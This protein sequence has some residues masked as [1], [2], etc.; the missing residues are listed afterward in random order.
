M[1]RMVGWLAVALVAIGACAAGPAWV[2][3]TAAPLPAGAEAVPIR[4][5]PIPTSIADDA[6]FGCP[7]ALMG[8]TVMVVD[9]SVTPPA[10]SYRSAETGEPVELAWSWG[11][12]AYERDGVVHIVAP[13]GADMM[14]EGQVADDLGGG[15]DNG[16]VFGVCDFR[17]MPR[18]VGS[19]P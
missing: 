1:R 3:P 2:F 12:S 16:N 15:F 10:V 6:A 4:V 9:R 5:Q 18:R 14:I 17:S 7:A 19:S 8:P 11:I 13:T